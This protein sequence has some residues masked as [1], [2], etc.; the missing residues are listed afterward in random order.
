MGLFFLPPRVAGQGGSA[1][2]FPAVALGVLI[3]HR[4]ANSGAMA[5]EQRD[6]MSD[7]GSGVLSLGDT[8][9]CWGHGVYG[10]GCGEGEAG[11]MGTCGRG[12]IAWPWVGRGYSWAKGAQSGYGAE[13]VGSHTVAMGHCA[14]KEAVGCLWGRQGVAVR[15]VG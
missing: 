11:T 12:D 10:R 2:V 13:G 5:E 7:R 1:G 6:L 3:A 4:G 8:Q 15:W 9:R 14:A